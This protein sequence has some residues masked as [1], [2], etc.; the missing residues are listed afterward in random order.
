MWVA[1][2]TRVM[3]SCAVVSLLFILAMKTEAPKNV[4]DEDD[5]DDD[6]VNVGNA[7]ETKE[8]AAVAPHVVQHEDV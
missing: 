8:Q 7:A 4:P 2:L 5:D 3:C 6:D 1:R